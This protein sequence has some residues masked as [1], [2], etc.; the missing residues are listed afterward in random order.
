M[1]TEINYKSK[2][3]LKA[4][5]EA[6]IAGTGKPVRVYQPGPFGNGIETGDLTCCIEGP[7]YPAP[8]RFYATA[9][10]KGGNVVKIK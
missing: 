5:V 6:S 10:V 4:A 9:T 3:D 8:H 2:K 1:Y 7:Q